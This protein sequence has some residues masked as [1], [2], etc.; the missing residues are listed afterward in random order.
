LTELPPNST[1]YTDTVDI[2]AGETI[3]YYLQLFGPGG[4]ENTSV[5]RMTC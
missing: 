1:S 3:E 2:A 5:M 4:T